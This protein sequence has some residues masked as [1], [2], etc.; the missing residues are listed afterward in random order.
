MRCAS[1]PVTAGVGCAGE[2]SAR[3]CFLAE[4]RPD[5]RRLV[6]RLAGLSSAALPAADD[7]DTIVTCLYLDG[8]RCAAGLGAVGGEAWPEWCRSCLE[9][10][11]PA[12]RVTE[13]EPP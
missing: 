13:G 6:L 10:L 2:Q 1:C 11:R 12:G 3:L 5:Y 4:T 8:G 9:S 7:A